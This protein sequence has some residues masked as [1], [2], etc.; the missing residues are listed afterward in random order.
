MLVPGD[1]LLIRGTD[2]SL[3]DRAIRWATRSPYSHAAIAV[4]ETAIVEA[5]R[6]RVRRVDNPYPGAWLVRPAYPDDAARDR[7]VACAL[8]Y[9]GTPY[10]V[11]GIGAMAVYTR[12]SVPRAL[13]ARL[14]ARRATPVFCSALVAEALAAGDVP[15]DTPARCTTPA[16]LARQLGAP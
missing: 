1:V 13:I 15:L 11:A 4:S 16:D 2:R 10:D 12:W 9:D 8:A 14:R 3:T 7:A 6:P 5:I